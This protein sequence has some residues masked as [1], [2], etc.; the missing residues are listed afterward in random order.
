MRLFSALGETCFDARMPEIPGRREEDGPRREDDHAEPKEGGTEDGSVTTDAVQVPPASESTAPVVQSGP[1]AGAERNSRDAA[2]AAD[3]MEAG[4]SLQRT[5]LRTAIYF[6]YDGVSGERKEP[7]RVAK[8]VLETILD[9]CIPPCHRAD[10][11][12][13]CKISE[14]L[15]PCALSALLW[16]AVEQAR[17]LQ[18]R[19]LIGKRDVSNRSFFFSAGWTTVHRTARQA[20]INRL[21]FRMGSMEYSLAS[22]LGI[23]CCFFREDL[24]F[25]IH[26]LKKW[27]KHFSLPQG[28]GALVRSL[29]YAAAFSLPLQSVSTVFA[30]SSR[31][32]GNVKKLI[33]AA[34]LT[35][36]KHLHQLYVYLTAA[37]LRLS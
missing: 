21:F 33:F 12:L 15:A 37:S 13:T 20:L 6:L 19:A 7:Y 25:E 17:I 26:R 9:E 30:E 32:R 16:S 2:A 1:P 35:Q 34:V 22:L 8:V 14:Y 27:P 5:A 11:S 31:R 3:P 18:R 36:V 10:M 28:F 29:I 24:F 23:V 4:N